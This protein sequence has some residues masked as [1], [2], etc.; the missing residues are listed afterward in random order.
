MAFI[1]N[2]GC[3]VDMKIN[4]SEFLTTENY[5]NNF[6]FAITA[7]DLLAL[8]YAAS[9]ILKADK[10]VLEIRLGKNIHEIPSIAV[11]KENLDSLEKDS[12]LNRDIENECHIKFS[13]IISIIT[14][15]KDYEK[16]TTY[17]D[18]PMY[19]NIKK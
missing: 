7:Q 6:L 2:M 16:S 3:G 1:F 8:E 12:D 18:F 9:K 17:Y 5:C 4:E 11:I 13:S 10:K 14:L 19:L 15:D